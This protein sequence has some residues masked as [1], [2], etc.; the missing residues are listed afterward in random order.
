MVTLPQTHCLLALQVTAQVHEGTNF[1][2]F[3]LVDELQTSDQQYRG[4]KQPFL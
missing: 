1:H 2:K 4:L 3:S